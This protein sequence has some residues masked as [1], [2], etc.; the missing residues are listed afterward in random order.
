MTRVSIRVLIALYLPALVVV[1]AVAAAARHYGVPV[2]ALTRDMAAVV[3]ASPFTGVLSVLGVTVWIATIS[4]VIFTL[5]LSWNHVEGPKRRFLVW[6][7]LLSLVLMLDDLFMFHELIAP[8][9]LG[10]R[11][12]Y[13]YLAYMAATGLGLLLYR[14]VIIDSGPLLLAAALACFTLSV[15]VD[16]FFCVDDSWLILLEDGA[17]FFGIVGWGGYFIGFS[18]GQFA[19]GRRSDETHS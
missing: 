14:R 4:I 12:R 13:V 3:H 6:F 10:L 8:D 16:V 7:A 19:G 15:G 18:A 17:K 9:Y 1:G 2:G 11:Q 5:A